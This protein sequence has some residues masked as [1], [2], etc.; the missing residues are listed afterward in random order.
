MSTAV[1]AVLNSPAL[2]GTAAPTAFRLA[3]PADPQVTVHDLGATRGDGVFET[4]GV[5]GGRAQAVDGHLARLARSAAMLELPEPDLD[6]W[7]ET[8]IAVAER[9]PADREGFVK[10]V[11]TRG[12]EGSGIP[13]GWAT[14]AVAPDHTEA[15]TRGIGVVVL[16]RGLPHDVT[17]T[18]P[19][20]LQGA[21]TLS[22]ALN[23]AALR[24][25]RRRDADDALFVSG[26][27]FLL[28]GATSTL[29]LKRG[30]RLVTPSTSLGI[31]PGTTQADAFRSARAEGMT[32]SYEVLPR[33]AL[34]D[35][36]GLWLLSSVRL[37]APIRTLDGTDRPVDEAFTA[38]L[39]AALLARRD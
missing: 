28:E 14:G 35:A 34:D 23:M 37:A 38:R 4:L 18:A 31:L 2:D 36:D 25:A 3:D 24:E 13:T 26:D 15:R 20:L 11:Y 17:A 33:T 7:R 39:N 19:W 32:T 5:V 29:L 30:D 10:L 22:Y 9:L 21:K 12:P 8:L 16:D 27:G 6:A 1:L